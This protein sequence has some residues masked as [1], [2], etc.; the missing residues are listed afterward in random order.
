MELVLD[1]NKRYSYADYLTWID[2]VRHELIDGFI[3]MMAGTSRKHAD[4]CRNIAFS[5][6]FL[7][8]FLKY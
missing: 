6:L 5:S 4:V 2:D 3:N 8:Q 1:L 7:V